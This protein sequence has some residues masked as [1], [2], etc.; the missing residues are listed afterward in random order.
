M[1]SVKPNTQA[2]IINAFNKTSRYLDDILNLDNPYFETM[3]T[4]IYPLELTLNK[5]NISN[6]KASFLDLNIS[7]HKDRITSSIYDKGNI[8]ILTLL[9]ILFWMEMCVI[10]LHTGF[11]FPN[12]FDLLEPIPCWKTLIAVICL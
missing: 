4:S 1:L 6:S 11:I 9:I 10:L 2:D 12:L 7:I 8:S 5:A 3:F